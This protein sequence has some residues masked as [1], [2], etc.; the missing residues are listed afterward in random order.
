MKKPV[1]C[2]HQKFRRFLALCLCCLLA[3]SCLAV[4]GSAQDNEPDAPAAPVSEEGIGGDSAPGLDAPDTA[5]PDGPAPDEDGSDAG[6][7][8]GAPEPDGSPAPDGSPEPD[9][10]PEPGEDDPTPQP[11]TVSFVLNQT[12]T[13]TLTVLSG[14]TIPAEDIPNGEFYASQGIV[15]EGWYDSEGEE[16]DPTAEPILEDTVFTAR[17]VR[18]VELLLNTKSH[19][20]YIKGYD[21]GTFRPERTVTRAEAA[22]MLFGLLKDPTPGEAAPEFSDVPVGQ[23]Y[24]EAV[25]KLAGLGIINGYSDGTFRPGKT[26]TRAEFIKIAASCDVLAEGDCPF[27][28]VSGW[29][30]PYIISAHQKGWIS[31]ITATTFAPDD[32]ITR[33]QAV[34]IINCLLGRTPDK[35]IKSKAKV[36]NFYDIFPEHWAY[37]HIA[38]ASTSHG[39]L[40]LAAGG[41]TWTTYE[42]DNTPIKTGW[43]TDNGHRYYVGSNGKYLRGE[44]TI[45][46]KSYRFDSDGAA[47]TGFFMKSGWKR[48]YKDGLMQ[49][50]ISGLGVVKGPY[51]IKVYKPANYLIIFAK[52]DDGKYN[53]PVRAML[54]SCG[55]PT[56]TGTYYTP[57]RYRWLQMVGGSWAQW[58]T[59]I[60]DSYLFHSVPNNQKNNYTM[61]ADEYNNLGTT[62][63]LGCIRLT[64]EDAKWIFDNC[65]LGTQVYISPTETSGPMAKPKGIKLPGWHTWDPTDPTAKYL[66]KQH[67]CH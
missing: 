51:Y 37:G 3:V 5:S 1:L 20:A 56:P 30:E 11:V 9:S 67:G 10:S 60:L 41:E 15:L 53:I 61:W 22:V 44:Q 23:W 18:H 63:S 55:N 27:K 54:A 6:E 47:S 36:K 66:C 43:V 59:Q 19:D 34:K 17:W 65:A 31:G 25:H 29:A 26:I 46:G 52:G 35:N 24:A 2:T 39:Y 64:C 7:P 13:V 16:T 38:E 32:G 40:T 28:D 42:Q 62:R 14:E 45:A 58:C 49:E 50:D 21:N 33:A 57:G 48:Y 12:D 8:D 4:P